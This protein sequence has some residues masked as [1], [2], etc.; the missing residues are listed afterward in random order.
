MTDQKKIPSVN[1]LVK[2]LLDTG[3]GVIAVAGY[4]GPTQDDGVRIYGSSGN[5]VGD[6]IG[7]RLGGFKTR[8][9]SGSIARS[10]SK[11]RPTRLFILKSRRT[12]EPLLHS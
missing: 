3:Q 6:A 9:L 1:P 11:Y 12:H 4:M 7:S 5:R 8:N 2:R 10:T